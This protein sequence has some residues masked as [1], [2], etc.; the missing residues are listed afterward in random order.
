MIPGKDRE[1]HYSLWQQKISIRREIN[2]CISSD[3]KKTTRKLISK[4]FRKLVSIPEIG[5]VNVGTD[6]DFVLQVL[7]I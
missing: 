5:N 3:T 7:F 4:S 6:F 1:T 2:E